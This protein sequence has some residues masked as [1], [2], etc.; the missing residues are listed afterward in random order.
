MD[1]APE[2]RNLGQGKYSFLVGRQRYTLTT[3]LEEE[4]FLRVVST[5]QNLV[6]SFRPTLSQDERMFLALMSMS[7]QL[8][9]VSSRITILTENLCGDK[10]KN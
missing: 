5:I 9:N 1:E 4:S 7:H 3:Q 2:I 6:N 8:D 10:E